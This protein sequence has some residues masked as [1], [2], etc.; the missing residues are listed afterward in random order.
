MKPISKSLR[1]NGKKSSHFLKQAFSLIEV[2]LAMGI[3]LITVLTLV[4]MMGPALK[5]VSNVKTADEI[6]SVVDSVNAFLSTSNFIDKPAAS[7]A[8][9]VSRFDAIYS[10]VQNDG[11]ATLFVFKW[12]DSVNDV[13]RQEIGF[14]NNQD[15]AVN[16]QSIV[17]ST[18][19][20]DGV[21]VTS[22][23]NNDNPITSPFYRVVLTASSAM[24]VENLVTEGAEGSYPRYTLVS[25]VGTYTGNYLAMEVRIFAEDRPLTPFPTATD[26][27]ALAQ[28]VPNFV[29]N[30]AI[31]RD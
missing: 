29:Y 14:E 25:P 17:N 8:P 28:S 12:Y 30:T 16:N 7:G 4:G 22:F 19:R 9:A 13:I 11:H 20:G 6:A 15:E 24:L 3:F 31:L 21:P 2:V 18:T 27:V 5:S 26:M 1:P 10:A 23:N